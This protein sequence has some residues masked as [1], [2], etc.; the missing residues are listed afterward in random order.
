MQQPRILVVEDET[1]IAHL[2]RDYLRRDG[3]DVV[4]AGEGTG[5]VERVESLAPVLV[6]LDLNLPG[7][8]G[9]A[10]CRRLRRRSSV[11]VIMLTARVDEEDRLEGFRAGADDYVC[12][13]FSAPELVARVQSVLRRTEAV[14][15]SATDDPAPDDGGRLVYRDV[16]LDGERFTC[17]VR[18]NP[19]QLTPTEF[20]MLHAML[21]KPGAVFS[22]YQLMR[23]VYEDHRVVSDRT[24]DSH[25]SHLRTKLAER[26]DGEELVHS[27]YGV[28]Y[29]AE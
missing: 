11:P 24:I 1:K 25:V 21:E 10:I 19:L 18:G 22:R 29:R 12:K 20:R 23:V 13:P 8:D 16:T 14:P 5:I 7:E 6:V 2:V 28:G 4:L 17:T 9:L 15:G 27:T 3:F 26:L